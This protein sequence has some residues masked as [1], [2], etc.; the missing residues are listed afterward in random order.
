MQ[1]TTTQRIKMY[2]EDEEKDAI[3]YKQLSNIATSTKA[4]EILFELANEEQHHS[5]YLKKLYSSIT[6]K[7]YTPL[8]VPPDLQG[9]FRENIL[10]KILDEIESYEKYTEQSFNEK[11]KCIKDI[12]LKLKND[13]K[14][15]STKL[16]YIL[17]Y[18]LINPK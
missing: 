17:L 16:I 12:F 11:N 18:E 2:I 10:N 7:K 9:T 4:R 13:E 8:V 14:M 15:H 3:T 1:I 6:G 5:D